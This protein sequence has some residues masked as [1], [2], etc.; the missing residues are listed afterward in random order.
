MQCQPEEMRLFELDYGE[1]LRPPFRI[2]PSRGWGRCINETGE[3]L[4]V[5]GPKHPRDQSIFDNSPYVLPP[6]S[7]TPDHWDCDGFF[8]PAD[9]M[10]KGWWRNQA[11]PIAV[12]FWDFRRFTVCRD[13]EI[14]VC[15]WHNGVF[16]PSQI[17]WAIPNL[18]IAEIGQRIGS[19]C[20]RIRPT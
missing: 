1:M 14:Y 11:G 13:T 18:S 10:F 17:N 12:K 6:G 9:R 20:R 4:L 16:E 15:P 2:L 19:G 3:I 5:Y 7:T 8:V